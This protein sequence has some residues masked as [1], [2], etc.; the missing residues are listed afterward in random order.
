MA[1]AARINAR[2]RTQ[3]KVVT[4]WADPEMGT[5]IRWQCTP[6]NSRYTAFAV[7]LSP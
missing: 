1:G 5:E 2:N 3:R 7:L 6:G 4:G